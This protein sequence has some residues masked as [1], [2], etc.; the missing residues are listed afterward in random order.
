M[1]L[2]LVRTALFGLG[3]AMTGSLAIA[4]DTTTETTTEDFVPQP[5][6]FYFREADGDWDLRCIR[7]ASEP[8]R[9]SCQ[10][11]QLM[12]DENDNSVAKFTMIP[13]PEDAQAVAGA[14]VTT[15]LETLLTRPL[16]MVIDENTPKAYPYV[17][18]DSEGCNVRMAFT[19]EEIDL[20]KKGAAA[21]ITIYPVGAPNDPVQVTLSLTGFTKTYD[22][23][24]TSM[25]GVATEE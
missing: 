2:R 19:A 25:T 15:P 13:L 17:W 22:A 6:E 5:G 12:K 3:L 4:Q 20:M 24:V 9:E 8:P 11:Y 16:V 23:V 10:L 21:K 1:T 18:C 7:D 14:T